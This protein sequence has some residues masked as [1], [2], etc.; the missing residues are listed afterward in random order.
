[1]KENIK[2]PFGLDH[3]RG[4]D[5]KPK[6]EN[7]KTFLHEMEA[8]GSEREAFL[9]LPCWTF[10]LQ[11]GNLKVFGIFGSR[12]TRPNLIQIGLSLSC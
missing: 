8:C 4:W 1:M 11:V 2:V 7:V 3:E 6:Q 5:V 9:K 12:F 10:T